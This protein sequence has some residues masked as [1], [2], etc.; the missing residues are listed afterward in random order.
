MKNDMHV[1]SY[2][3]RGRYSKDAF[4]GRS[5]DNILFILNLCNVK[6]SIR[7][8]VLK[9]CNFKTFFQ[10]KCALAPPYRTSTQK[11]Y[12]KPKVMKTNK[13]EKLQVEKCLI[14]IN[15]NK[16]VNITIST[17]KKGS[18][19]YRYKSLSVCPSRCESFCL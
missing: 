2:L 19:L 11:K 8:Y 16:Y 12:Q 13:E 10:L 17:N 6:Q 5:E 3:D 18:N 9:R 7:Q 15:K 14:S 4:Y 1:H